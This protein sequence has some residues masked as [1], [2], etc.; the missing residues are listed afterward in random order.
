MTGNRARPEIPVGIL[1][2][3]HEQWREVGGKEPLLHV[4]VSYR[5]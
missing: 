1:L 3:G 4:A 5:G 2:G